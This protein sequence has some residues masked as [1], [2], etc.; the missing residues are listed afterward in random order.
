LSSTIPTI[1]EELGRLRQADILREVQ[2][3]QYVRDV[4]EASKRRPADKLKRRLRYP[5]WATTQLRLLAV[6]GDEHPSDEDL[7]RAEHA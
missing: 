4:A 3:C 7:R 2:R 6:P 1:H 5:A